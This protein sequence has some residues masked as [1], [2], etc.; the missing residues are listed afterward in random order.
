[1]KYFSQHFCLW[2]IDMYFS[3]SEIT[4][5]IL[6]GLN[7]IESKVLMLMKE[8]TEDCSEHGSKYIDWSGIE[9]EYINDTTYYLEGEN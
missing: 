9:I 8:G 6:L 3:K 5:F 1:M 2:I 4:I 7:C